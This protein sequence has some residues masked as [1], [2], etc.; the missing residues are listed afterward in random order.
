MDIRRS[1]I[2]NQFDIVNSSF[3]VS[4]LDIERRA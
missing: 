4:E 2:Q 1:L 3:K